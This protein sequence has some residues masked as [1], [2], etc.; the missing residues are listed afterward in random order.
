MIILFHKRFIKKHE[1]LH[2]KEKE[3]VAQKIEIFGV[4]PFNETLR[5]HALHGKYAGYRSIDIK[6]DL[7]AL[8]R[9]ESP[10]VARFCYLGTHHELY[11]S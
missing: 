6:S 5:N 2:P 10:D 8:Y 1:K 9:E 7:L 3:L 4:D 11:G